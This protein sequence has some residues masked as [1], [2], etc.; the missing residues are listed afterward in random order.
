MCIVRGTRDAAYDS[1]GYVVGP[2]LRA[3]RFAACTPTL[4]GRLGDPPYQRRN[5]RLVSRD[6]PDREADLSVNWTSPGFVL[7]LAGWYGFLCSWE[8]LQ[9]LHFRSH[10]TIRRPEK[11]TSLTTISARKCRIP[12]AGWRMPIQWKP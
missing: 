7:W 3:G 8:S 4:P 10:S 11:P 12:I 1:V 6:Y 9:R 2:D 5:L